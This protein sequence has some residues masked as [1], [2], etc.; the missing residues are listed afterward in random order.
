MYA[1]EYHKDAAKKGVNNV[2]LLIIKTLRQLNLHREDSAG[3][4][5]NIVV[6]NC[7][8]QNKNNTVLKMMVWIQQMGNFKMV[9]FVFLIV[10]ITKD[11]TDQLFNYLKIKYCRE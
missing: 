10:G 7:L 2:A 4:E 3:S 8:G 6:D 5:L 9:N 1:P 11:A